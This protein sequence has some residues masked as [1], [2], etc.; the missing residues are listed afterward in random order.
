VSVDPA[1]SWRAALDRFEADI[2]LAVSG[3]TPASWTPPDGLGPC[4][5][6]LTGRALRILDAL[7]ETEAILSKERQRAGAH[8]N[9]LNAVQNPRRA[10]HP[11][12]LDIRG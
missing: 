1:A 7:R 9:A 5:P 8:L 6:E 12:F 2:G 3:G 11:L 4:P 10:G